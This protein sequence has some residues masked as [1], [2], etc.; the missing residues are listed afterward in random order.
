M[1]H[2][3]NL[4]LEYKNKKEPAF[5]SIFYET[6][7]KVSNYFSPK[8]STSTIFFNAN[9]NCYFTLPFPGNRHKPFGCLE[10]PNSCFLERMSIRQSDLLNLPR[11]DSK[12][13]VLTAA[14]Q[15][16]W[17]K[18]LVCWAGQQQKTYSLGAFKMSTIICLLLLT[19]LMADFFLQRAFSM[20]W[21]K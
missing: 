14:G 12:K 18:P 17:V 10:E 7:E 15:S 11:L 3:F 2:M 21:F 1:K 5:F 8:S 13:S 6:K 9:T 4:K 16:D 19:W 20:C